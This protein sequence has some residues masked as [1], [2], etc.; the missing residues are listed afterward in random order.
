MPLTSIYRVFSTIDLRSAY[1]QVSIRESDKPYTTIQAGAAL[2]QFTRIPFGVT[3]GVACFQRTMTDIIG[4]KNLQGTFA[5]VD[6]VTICGSV[7]STQR[8]AILDYIVGKGEIKPDPERLPPFLQLPTPNDAKSLHRVLGFFSHYSM[9]I[10]RYSEKIRPLTTT[11]TF[12]I[13]SE[14]PLAFEN[15]KVDIVKSVVCAIDEDTPFE[16]ETDASDYA[17]AATLNQNGRPVAFFCRMLHGPK[18]S[19]ASVEKEAKA[20]IEAIHHWRHY[21]TGQHFTITT[22]QRSVAYIFD[23][24]E[25]KSKTIKLCGGGRSCLATDLKWSTDQGLKTSH[26]ILYPGSSVLPFSLFRMPA[27][28]HSNRGAS[29][30]SQELHCFFLSKGIATSRTTPYNPACN[31]QVEKYNGTVWK[32]TMMALETQGLPVTCWQDVFPDAL[33]SLRSLLCTVTNCTPHERF[34]KFVRHSSTGGSV[35]TQ[36]S[37]P[38]PVLLK[39]HVRAS[40]TDPLVKLSCWRPIHSTPTFDVLMGGKLL[41]PFDI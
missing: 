36:L 5:Y 24:S 21:L 14:A 40:K 8:L 12:P 35:P 9:W 19:H 32:A 17:I 1:H 31:G 4:S 2:Y 25:E 26:L 27:Y 23:N 34:L 13:S 33:H 41:C 16:V 15:L 37:T 38:G 39:C 28:I 30:I 22:D 6:N 20:I 18:V 11:S 10:Q 29:Y 7:F 3:N